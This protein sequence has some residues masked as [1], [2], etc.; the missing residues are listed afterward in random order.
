MRGKPL[1]KREGHNIKRR[2]KIPFLEAR[3]F[4]E[5]EKKKKRKKEKEKKN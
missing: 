1:Y 2:P 5:E 3:C 4:L